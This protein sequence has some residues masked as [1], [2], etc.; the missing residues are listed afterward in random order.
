[1]QLLTSW[2]GFPILGAAVTI[3]SSSRGSGYLAK[4]LPRDLRMDF[5]SPLD[6][7]VKGTL[8]NSLAGLIVLV[9][10]TADDVAIRIV[11]DPINDFTALL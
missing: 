2:W 4:I 8:A 3:R 6:I 9:Q 10:D 7:G 11:D 5:L 1:M